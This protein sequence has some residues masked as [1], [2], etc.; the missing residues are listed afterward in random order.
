MLRGPHFYLISLFRKRF[1]E[2][3]MKRKLLKATPY[4]TR[5]NF[6]QDSHETH[7]ALRKQLGLYTVSSIFVLTVNQIDFWKRSYIY[8]LDLKI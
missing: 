2:Q 5:Q 7:F 6:A 1:A 3:Q 8:L 4:L